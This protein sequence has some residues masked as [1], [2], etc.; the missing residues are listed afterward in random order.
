MDTIINIERAV[1]SAILYAPSNYEEVAAFLN[2]KDFLYP[3][4]KNVFE[5]M[6]ECDALNLPLDE[7]IILQR[8]QGKVREEEIVEI[9]SASPIANIEAY[10]KEIKEAALKRELQELANL[11][12][13]K[14]LDSHTSSQEIMEIVEKRVSDIALGNSNGKDFIDSP[15]LVADT[16]SY[17]LELKNR[18]N[19][20]LTGVT[21]GFYEL[22]DITTGFNNG[23]LVIIGARPSMGKTAFMLSIAQSIL[24]TDV[25]VAIFSLEMPALQLM[26]R[27]LSSLSSISMQNLRRGNLND[28]ELEQ[29]SICTDTMEKKELFI[30]DGS[31]LNIAQLR[32]KLRKLK[33][34]HP[35]VGIAM[36]D[37][38]QLMVGDRN[39]GKQIEISDI[40]R[41]LKTLA[42]ELQMPIIAL[43]QLNRE[44]EKRDDKRPI[45]SDLR[46]SGAIEQ[47]ADMIL[48]LYRD[49]V[50]KKRAD[51]ERKARLE[52]E[53]KGADFKPEYEERDVEPAEV[54]VAKNR[55]GETKTIKIQF[56]KRFTRF[57]N[58]NKTQEEHSDTKLDHDEI[59][60]IISSY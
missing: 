52:K 30:D 55:N 13:E 51:K 27:L 5:V 18:G 54:I 48:F 60:N 59:K 12:R 23:D 15:T 44:L 40:S 37:Y 46:D 3:T 21:T 25:G 24:H 16:M 58:P 43:S 39:Q 36:I 7:Q 2:P 57:E 17:L 11:L 8:S 26:I 38:L 33:R 50:Y 22:N 20:I 49:D 47:D 31:V 14:S 35:N 29:L 10:T 6:R 42:R 32:S 9:A 56:R 53:G 45:L 34:Q 28:A 19:E 41:G 4:H 1:L